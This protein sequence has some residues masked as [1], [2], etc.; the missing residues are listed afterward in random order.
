MLQGERTRATRRIYK[1]WAAKF[2]AFITEI[3]LEQVKAEEAAE[4]HC[5]A[6]GR[7]QRWMH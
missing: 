1:G 7:R 5:Q 4:L 6:C 3:N 2:K